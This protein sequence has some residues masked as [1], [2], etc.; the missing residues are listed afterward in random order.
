VNDELL[1]F[2][3]EFHSIIMMMAKK[4]FTLKRKYRRTQFVVLVGEEEK[5]GKIDRT[6]KINLMLRASH[7]VREEISLT[8][9]NCT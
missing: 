3:F 6:R 9:S 4:W 7:K 1:F 2:F 8:K 5:T